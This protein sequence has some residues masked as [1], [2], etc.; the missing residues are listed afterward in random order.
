[1][2]LVP[3]RPHHRGRVT[4]SPANTYACSPPTTTAGYFRTAPPDLPRSASLRPLERNAPQLALPRCRPSLGLPALTVDNRVLRGRSPLRSSRPH[5][6]ASRRCA[7]VRRRRADA[8]GLRLRRE[9]PHPATMIETA[10]GRPDPDR[11]GGRNM[12][13][14]RRA[15]RQPRGDRHKH[16]APAR[17]EPQFFTAAAFPPMTYRTYPRSRSRRGHHRAG[18][19]GRGTRPIAVAAEINNVTRGRPAPASRMRRAHRSG[20]DIAYPSVTCFPVPGGRDPPA[21]LRHPRIQEDGSIE[22]IDNTR[23]R[24]VPVPLATHE[25]ARQ[26]AGPPSAS[27]APAVSRLRACRGTAR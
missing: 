6:I 23:S 4:F 17:V 22:T 5:R 7:A 24:R 12:R 15:D 25:G 2:R 26:H 21:Q 1:M 19:R 9:R 8:V 14:A 11:R 16:L 18:R 13:H 10:W 20:P 27:A 3:V